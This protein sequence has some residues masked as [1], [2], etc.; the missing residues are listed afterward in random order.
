MNYSTAKTEAAVRDAGKLILNAEAYNNI[1]MKRGSANFVTTVD[2]TVQKYLIDELEGIIPESK[3]ICEE[4]DNNEYD[5]EGYTWIMDPIDGTTNFIYGY[6]YSAISLALFKDGEAL[7]GFVFNPYSDE[8]FTA[9]TGKGAFLN[10]GKITAGSSGSLE[11][12]LIAFGTTP[13]DR[14]E[15]ELTFDMV[16][17]VFMK[18]RDIRRSG[19]AALDLACVAAGRIDGFFELNLQPWDYAAGMLI[20]Q[21]AGG[22]VTDWRGGNLSALKP[23]SVLATNGNIHQAMMGLLNM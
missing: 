18:S 7:A 4:S 15:A 20:V 2:Y 16:K 14:A 12:S 11:D 17:K 23:G 6:R 5:P 1:I 19:S 8:M 9:E 13:Y 21:E 10:G 3:F 22:I